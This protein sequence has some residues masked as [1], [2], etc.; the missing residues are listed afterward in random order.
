MIILIG[1]PSCSGKTYLAQ[2][3]LE[4]YKIPY[5]SIDHIKMGL[6]RSNNSQGLTPYDDNKL[7]AFLWPI[8]K[9][10]IKTNIENEQSIIIEGCYLPYSK[11]YSFT[12]NYKKKIIIL[13]LVF[14]KNY[15]DNN[16]KD[17]I[18]NSSIIED[19]K[20]LTHITKTY[21][22]Q[23]HKSVKE[24]CEKYKIP[25]IH[26]DKNFKTDIKKAFALIDRF[27]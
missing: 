24:K 14:S 12:D 13:Y 27:I 3:V 4:R 10:I 11:I 23:E 8:I 18:N 17:I 26:I 1:G 22:Y 2:K 9:E 21:L 6:I 19:K 20:D 25:Y 7:T 5:L 16:Y 15:I